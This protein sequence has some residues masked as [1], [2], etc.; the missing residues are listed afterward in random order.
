MYG[1][2]KFY[3]INF[4]K[5]VNA[6]YCPALTTLTELEALISTAKISPACYHRINGVDT[7]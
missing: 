3:L 4:E 5:L 2:R 7:S 1:N 6:L